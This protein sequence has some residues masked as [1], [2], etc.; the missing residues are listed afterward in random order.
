MIARTSS[1]VWFEDVG[2]EDIP[3]VGGKGAN[4]GELTRAKIPVPPGFVVTADTYF[5]FI[6]ERA[7]EPLIKKDLFGLN[8]HD[9]KQLRARA[10]QIRNRILEAEMPADIADEIREAYVRLGEGLVAVRSSATAED[11]PE[12][13]FVLAWARQSKVSNPAALKAS[14]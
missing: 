5:H 13:I 3:L 11:L 7:L 14:R 12:A 9:S 1:V 4:L 8:V 2:K 6:H 10:E